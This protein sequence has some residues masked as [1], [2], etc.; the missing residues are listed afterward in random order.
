M[1]G[2]IWSQYYGSVNTFDYDDD[3]YFCSVFMWSKAMVAPCTNHPKVVASGV[4]ID[5]LHG[6]VSIKTWTFYNNT[7]NGFL[8]NLTGP[9]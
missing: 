2:G 1:K 4:L 5:F 6:V 9:P 7:T 3:Y 8:K